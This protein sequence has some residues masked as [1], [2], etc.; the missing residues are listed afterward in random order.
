[1]KTISSYKKKVDVYKMITNQIISA[2]EEETIPWRKT[3]TSGLPCNLV[4]MKPYQG[5]NLLLLSLAS[6]DR[7][8]VTYRQASQMGGNIKKGAKS[9]PIV[10]WN[11]TERE[12]VNE[13]T[14]RIETEAT[15]FMRYYR[16]FGISQTENLEEHIPAKRD[17]AEIL[18]CE[19]IISGN[20]PA[21]EPGGRPSY[22]PARDTIQMPSIGEFH[23]SEDYYSTFFHELGHWTGH[24]SRL[25]REEV[26]RV[27][28]FGSS[29]YSKE[30]LVAELTASFLCSHLS[31]MNTK[32][33][34]NETAY[35]Q[36]WLKVLKSDKRF[37]VS[38]SSK[39]KKATEYILEH[40]TPGDDGTDD[41]VFEL[42]PESPLK[43]EKP[44][45]IGSQHWIRTYVEKMPDILSWMIINACP[46]F[47]VFDYK[48]IE[49]ISPVADNNYYEHRST[50][51]E[52]IG[53]LEYKPLLDRFWPANK[54]VWDGLSVMR[55]G[56]ECRFLVE[57][58]SHIRETITSMMAT[59][60]KSIKSIRCTFSTVK[61]Y[62]GVAPDVDWTGPYYQFCNRL[63][64]LY[65][66]N[67]VLGQSTYLTFVNFIDDSTGVPPTSIDQW[68]RH[69]QHVYK[70][71]GISPDAEILKRV[72]YI[73]PT[74]RL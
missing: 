26:I 34:E 41:D 25:N 5:I 42:V 22:S 31:I 48:D 9:V 32:I 27:A 45:I 71:I 68:K 28:Y 70:T 6:S 56:E 8:F 21:V 2:L 13:S 46:D 69:Y 40:T 14:G 47:K 65:F 1:M 49:W 12:V 37:V 62:L 72:I 52:A 23:S 55:S 54:P 4:S 19:Q 11:I 63:A 15:P 33:I 20:N 44:K 58:K 17:N 39:A 38:A 50:L 60:P 3:W 51:L 16:V 74:A 18:T 29:D 57:A 67:V 43:K 30:E 64:F 66:M 24:K 35:I 10:Y 53:L 61:Q 59:D 36:S 73:Y 7:Y